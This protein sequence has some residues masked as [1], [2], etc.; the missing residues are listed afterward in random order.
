MHHLMT[1][2]L[3]R[4]YKEE[5]LQLSLIVDFVVDGGRDDGGGGL[6]ARLGRRYR[7]VPKGRKRDWGQG[8]SLKWSS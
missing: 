3:R 1:R 7:A 6:V 2:Q 8:E 5:L 4:S